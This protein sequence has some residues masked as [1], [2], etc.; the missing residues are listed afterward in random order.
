MPIYEYRCADCGKSIEAIQ[1]FSDEPYTNCGQTSVVCDKKGEGQ[2]ER[3]L[4]A[5]TFQFKGTG[6]YITDYANGK[7]SAAEP[8]SSS[9]SDSKSESKSESK[10]ETKTESKPAESK[11]AESK[12][13]ATTKS[14]T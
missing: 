14:D 7:K 3:Q 2:I 12:P 1:K 5:P 13:A 11:H 10:T 4:T 8:K 6:F 9:T